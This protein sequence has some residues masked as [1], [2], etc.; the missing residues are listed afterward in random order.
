MDVNTTFLKNDIN[1]EVYAK[2]PPRWCENSVKL[3]K[4]DVYSMKR[5]ANATLTGICA[6]V[7]M[8]VY[9]LYYVGGV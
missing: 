6:S 5:I 9:Y 4:E 7:E 3:I 8:Y 2:L 1:V